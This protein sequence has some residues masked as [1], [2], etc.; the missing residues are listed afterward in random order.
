M[1]IL[2]QTLIWNQQG[3]IQGPLETDDDFQKRAPYLEHFKSQIRESLEI[4]PEQQ[5]KGDA[6]LQKAFHKTR[7]LYGIEPAFVPIFFSNKQLLFFHGGTSWIVQVEKDLPIAAFIQLKNNK[8]P[9]YSQ[10]EI[11]VH[12][13]SHVGRMAYDCPSFEEILAWSSSPSPF[14]RYFGP[15]FASLKE[16][17][18]LLFILITLFIM[19]T[20]TL[21]MGN[22][23][24]FLMLQWLKIIPLIFI[25]YALGRL[26]F[27]QK[28]FSSCLEKLQSMR[29]ADIA[30]A[31]IYRLSD[32]EIF[33]FS[34]QTSEEIL[35]YA[36]V[37]AK[38]VLRWKTLYKA[39]FE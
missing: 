27:R 19:D 2:D 15:L 34:K 37:S 17:S 4:T 21:F 22:E 10:E 31:V 11:L 9:F 39:Y 36:A 23:S 24:T 5:E 26:F 7:A 3:I 6:I 13:L 1:E 25:V 35:S 29:G 33:R 38:N 12:E 20:M 32:E 16:T 30:K 8:V 28:A 18:L 14:R